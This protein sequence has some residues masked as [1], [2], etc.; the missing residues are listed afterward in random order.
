MNKR[1]SAVMPLMAA[2]WSRVSGAV[3]T[4]VCP[5]G[6]HIQQRGASVTLDDLFVLMQ[7]GEA[8]RRATRRNRKEIADALTTAGHGAREQ[9]DIAQVIL[10]FRESLEHLRALDTTTGLTPCLEGLAMALLSAHQPAH[11]VCLWGAASALREARQTPLTPAER[12]THQ[13][14]LA[15]ARRDL[16]AKEFDTAWAMGVAL[17]PA[18]AIVEAIA[19]S[20]DVISQV[21][22][23]GTPDATL[24][25]IP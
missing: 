23:S 19:S 4:G 16:A 15:A 11:G 18:Q 2:R 25:I 10:Y 13:Q 21:A 14:A 5:L 8:E 7:C 3:R 17:T 6:A 12:R 24:K 20:E 22:S 1:P 9:G